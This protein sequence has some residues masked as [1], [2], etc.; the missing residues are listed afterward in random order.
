MKKYTIGLFSE[1]VPAIR[2]EASLT[3]RNYA[4]WLNR[5]M[6]NV[7]M[8]SPSVPG[9]V[10]KED[11]TVLRY[12]SFPIARKRP[13]RAG[14][15]EL[16]PGLQRRLH[17][18]PFDLLHCHS[19]FAGGWYALRLARRK[20]IP[21]VASFYPEQ[22]RDT[23]ESVRPVIARTMV[24]RMVNFYSAVDEVWVQTL[25]AGE[26]LCRYGYK[27]RV[28][29]MVSD[30]ESDIDVAKNR[31]MFVMQRK[32]CESMHR[33]NRVPWPE[34]IWPDPKFELNELTA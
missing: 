34:R 5:T 24:R 33:Q 6:D 28:T 2:D 13:Y 11:F 15:P 16:T 30:R 23:L 26:T 20:N 19:P 31:Y 8:I 29:T 25:A 22:C 21:V 14:F 17:N 9:Y 7:Y 10:D 12:A 18:I 32:K 4:C 1:Y 27:G 3:I